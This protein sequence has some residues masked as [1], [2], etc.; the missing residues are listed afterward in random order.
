MLTETIAAVTHTKVNDISHGI[1]PRCLTLVFLAN[2]VNQRSHVTK[3]T[4]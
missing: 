1:I 4:R 2:R 3:V